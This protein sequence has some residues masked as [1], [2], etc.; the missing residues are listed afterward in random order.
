VI[1]SSRDRDRATDEPG[2][3]TDTGADTDGAAG[4]WKIDLLLVVVV[5]LLTAPIA[6]HWT[7]Q[8]SSRYLLTM[9]IVD[10]QS[11]RLDP[12]EEFIGQDHAFFEGH[13]YSDKAPYQ[14]VLAAP[15]YQ[16]YR[17]VGGDP[18]PSEDGV[19]HP[20]GGTNYGLWWVTLWSATIPAAVLA[21]V[22]RRLVARVYPRVAT[23]VALGLAL[24]TLLLPF[25][26][27]LFS[28]V[29]SALLVALVWFLLRDRPTSKVAIGA[30][31]ILGIGIG[32]EYSIAA[33]A[34][35]FLIA[36]VVRRQRVEA[37]LL[38][39]ATVVTAAPILLY[40]WLVYRDPFTVSYAGH[41]PHFQGEGTLG[42][43]NIQPPEIDQFVRV[44]AGD[45]G[46]LVLT[47]VVLCAVVGGVLAITRKLPTQVDA[48]VGL[49]AF[50]AM[51][52][53]SSAI[54]AYGHASP[55]PRYL[56]PVLPLLAIPLA[57]SWRRQPKICAICAFIGGFFMLLATIT[58]PLIGQEDSSAP[59][60]WIEAFFD[61]VRAPTVF[62]R[63]LPDATIYVTTALGLAALAWLIKVD[64]DARRAVAPTAG[65]NSRAGT[66]DA[67]QG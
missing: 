19:V 34:L 32:V 1:A 42:V 61:G 39:A 26:T 67:L 63:L 8:P 49:S 38:S 16:L 15:V 55:G 56:V 58:V 29:L 22:M 57:E 11:L 18:L 54:T 44:L 45:R 30:G 21:V 62:D 31:L 36:T 10:D 25:A 13:L 20:G 14:P 9:A 17:W 40:N 4:G 24:G 3:D 60:T 23:R 53:F 65:L 37:V 12:Y 28:H 52:L 50:A 66:A 46:I 33:F 7:D 47:P 43:Y 27:Q 64:R 41:M 2:G 5:L 48:W 59:R 6:Q 51:V 35:I